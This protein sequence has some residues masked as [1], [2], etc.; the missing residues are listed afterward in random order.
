ME[1]GLLAVDG[2][3]PPGKKS[4]EEKKS[5]PFQCLRE[6]RLLIVNEAW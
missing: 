3:E 5:N 1:L 6:E 2:K 4:W